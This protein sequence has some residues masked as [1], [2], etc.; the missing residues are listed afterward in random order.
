M[1]WFAYIVGVVHVLVG[2]HAP[3]LGRG[4]VYGPFGRDPK[5]GGHPACDNPA[6]LRTANES[7]LSS[8]RAGLFVASKRHKCWDRLLVCSAHGNRCAVLPVADVGPDRADLDIYV[9][10][11]KLLHHDG[12]GIIY[13]EMPR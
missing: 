7:A 5:A 10:A 4:T 9:D 12:E 6:R 2:L 11:A 1:S 8:Y 13:M 3:H